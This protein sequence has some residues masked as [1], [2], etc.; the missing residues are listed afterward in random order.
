[1]KTGK[2]L[3]L[4]G[5]TV[6]AKGMPRETGKVY[7]RINGILYDYSKCYISPMMAEQ[8]YKSLCSLGVELKDAPASANKEAIL[9]RVR[10]VC[11]NLKEYLRTSTWAETDAEIVNRT[12]K[13]QLRQYLYNKENNTLDVVKTLARNKEIWNQ[14]YLPCPYKQ[15]IYPNKFLE[16]QEELITLLSQPYH[17]EEP[18]N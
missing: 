7:L 1:M 12:L 4:E 5:M 17:L 18:R 8:L 6:P 13:Y 16:M 11:T 10:L 3:G 14:M 2:E 15:G 9:S